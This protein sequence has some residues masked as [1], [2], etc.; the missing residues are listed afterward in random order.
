MKRLIRVAAGI[1]VA[2]SIAG[3]ASS[4]APVALRFE[5][6]FDAARTSANGTPTWTGTISGDGWSGSLEARLVDYRAA[7]VTEHVQV[8]HL[9]EAGARSF[10]F[11]GSGTFNNI[12]NRIV[13]DGEVD[14][15]WMAGAQVHDEALRTEPSLSRF[16][17]TF[18]LTG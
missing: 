9:V 13:L 15:G 4:D 10:T 17:G 12:T 8:L 5:K 7:A 3:A 11:V 18:R 16:V 2:A 6:Q 1:V 14:S